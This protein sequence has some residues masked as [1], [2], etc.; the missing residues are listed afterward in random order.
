[1]DEKSQQEN[2]F[3]GEGEIEEGGKVEKKLNHWLFGSYFR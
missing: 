3:M 2:C 1:M